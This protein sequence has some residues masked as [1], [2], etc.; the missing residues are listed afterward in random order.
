MAWTLKRSLVSLT[1]VVAAAT[2]VVAFGP[3]PRAQA[4]PEPSMVAVSWEL[5]FKSEA[6]ERIIIDGKPFWYMRYTVTNNTG[7]DVLFVPQFQLISDTGQVVDGNRGLKRTVY[8]KIKALYGGG[9]MQSP[10]EVLGPILQGAD[11]AKDSVAI[12]GDVDADTR[13]IRITISG[14]SGETAEVIDPLTS[15]T[16]VLHKT[17]VLEYKLPGEQIG[18]EPQPMLKSKRWV[19]K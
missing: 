9:F 1:L 18:I 6:P 11:N 8:D 7:K 5:E 10:F 3:S 4:H 16:V 17:L 13:N 2:A 19:M 12:F 15:K 14:L